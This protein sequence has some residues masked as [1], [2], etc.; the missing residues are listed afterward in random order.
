MKLAC[1]G[2]LSKSKLKSEPGMMKMILKR[3]VVL[4]IKKKQQIH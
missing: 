3:T 1:R 2:R 4:K